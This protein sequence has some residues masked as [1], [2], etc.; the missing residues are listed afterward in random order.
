[1]DKNEFRETV[2]PKLFAVSICLITGI[3]RHGITSTRPPW[4]EHQTKGDLTPTYA[5]CFQSLPVTSRSGSGSNS[6]LD[7]E[8]P[9]RARLVLGV[10]VSFFLFFAHLMGV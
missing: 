5:R 9:P 1:M 2:A 3:A 4:L 8:L 10:V 7:R 6:R